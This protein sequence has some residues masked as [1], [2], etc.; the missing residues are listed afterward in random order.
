MSGSGGRA[1]LAVGAASGAGAASCT[2]VTGSGGGALGAVALGASGGSGGDGRHEAANEA[3]AARMAASVA[4]GGT[5]GPWHGEARAASLAR[6]RAFP[7]N[8]AVPYAPR[9]MLVP[10]RAIVEV[11]GG[12]LAY[13]KAVLDPGRTLRIG[14]SNLADLALPHDAQMSAEH[15][16]LTWDGERCHVRDLDSAMGTWLGGE[17]VR[18]GEVEHAGLLEAGSTCFRVYFE[19]HTPPRDEDEVE[20]DA[21]VA[22]KAA[23]LAELSRERDAA[24]PQAPGQRG[25]RLFAVVDASRGARPLRL[26]REAVDDHQSLYQG[27]KGEALDGCAPYLVALRADSGLLERLV[28]EGLGA[29]WGIYLACARPFKDVRR[30]LRRFLIV[31]DDVTAEKYYFRFYD[32]S[33]LRAFLPACTPR[34]RADFFGEVACFFAEGERGELRRFARKT[35]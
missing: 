21:L 28:Q 7:Q 29:R 3:A 22:E 25:G 32:P 12:P 2:G 27:V 8:A 15:L 4:R 31:E 9:R 13:R 24:H 6:P 35:S 1:G 19:A 14:R 26:L 33:A 23:A 11:R 17:R 18:E 20:G 34:Q 5:R 10:K 16:A 30:H